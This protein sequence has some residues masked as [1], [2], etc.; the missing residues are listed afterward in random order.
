MYVVI[1][2][3]VMNMYVNFTKLIDNVNIAA[4]RFLF[5]ILQLFQVLSIQS[6]MKLEIR[7][8]MLYSYA[9]LWVNQFQTSVGTLIVQ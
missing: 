3:T 8:T 2:Y 7:Q 9:K 5:I 1:Y 4:L 6:V